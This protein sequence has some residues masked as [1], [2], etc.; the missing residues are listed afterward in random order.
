VN[1][2]I[3]RNEPNKDLGRTIRRIC[4][5]SGCLAMMRLPYLGIAHIP[6]WVRTWVPEIPDVKLAGSPEVC[7]W[8]SLCGPKTCAVRGALHIGWTLPLLVRGAA[9]RARGAGDALGMLS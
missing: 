7:A 5:L 8:E 6:D 3:F 9:R 2:F 4:I 1:T